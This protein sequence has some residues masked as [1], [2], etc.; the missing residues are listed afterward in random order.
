MPL[1]LYNYKVHTSYFNCV[2]N[3]TASKVKVA[4]I[5]CDVSYG[6]KYRKKVTGNHNSF[7]KMY[8][9]KGLYSLCQ[10]CMDKFFDLFFHI[11]MN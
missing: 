6:L 3:V 11:L 8:P 9:I 7:G 10:K 5:V 2:M 4:N 1:K